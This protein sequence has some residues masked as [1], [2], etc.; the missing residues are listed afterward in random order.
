[1]KIKWILLISIFLLIFCVPANPG[2]YRGAARFCL[3]FFGQKFS[4]SDFSLTP[5]GKL[6]KASGAVLIALYNAYEST[7]INDAKAEQARRISIA[8][9]KAIKTAGE[10]A[11]QVLRQVDDEDYSNVWPTEEEHDQALCRVINQLKKKK[12]ISLKKRQ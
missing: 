6:K 12:K 4:A 1:M 2:T 3:L 7:Y 10:R 9:S 8:R 11:E 5:S